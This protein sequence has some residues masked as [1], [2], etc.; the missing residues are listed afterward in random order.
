MSGHRELPFIHSFILP[1]VEPRGSAYARQTLYSW[2]PLQ[3]CLVFWLS[4]I[5][6]C[7]WNLI[8]LFSLQWGDNLVSSSF[9]TLFM[10]THINVLEQTFENIKMMR[11]SYDAL[12]LLS[13]FYSFWRF[14]HLFFWHHGLTMSPKLVS[15]LRFSCLSLPSS[16]L[17]ACTSTSGLI[18]PNLRDE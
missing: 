5:L 10:M 1:R 18:L 6:C 4:T 17:W 2:I 13:H 3:F 11:T 9:L 12:W 16:G 7:E 14:H 15:N 8:Y